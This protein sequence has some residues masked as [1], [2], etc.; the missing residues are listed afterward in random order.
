MIFIFPCKFALENQTVIY[1]NIRYISHSPFVAINID[2]EVSQVL[3]PN[4]QDG[5]IQVQ[6]TRHVT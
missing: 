4:Q 2:I 1:I 5:Q 3:F 6:L